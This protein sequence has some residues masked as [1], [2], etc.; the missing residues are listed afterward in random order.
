MTCR[1]CDK[2]IDPR[3][4]YDVIHII[5]Q[6]MYNNLFCNKFCVIEYLK[7]QVTDDP[8]ATRRV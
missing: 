6:G 5:D 2:P 7:K 1:N 3:S 8:I 4:Y